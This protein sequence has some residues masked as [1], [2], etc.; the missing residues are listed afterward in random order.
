[1]EKTNANI[2]KIA[3]VGAES[4]GKTTLCREL[5]E[6]YNDLWLPEYARTYV[7]NLGHPYNWEDVI[8]IAEEQCRLEKEYEKKAKKMLFLD[9]DLIITKVWFQHVWKSCPDW[10]DKEIKESERL[11]YLLCAPSTS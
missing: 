4:T 10:I 11:V 9:T 8:H 1:M 6:H 7:E 2:F 3:V 5:A